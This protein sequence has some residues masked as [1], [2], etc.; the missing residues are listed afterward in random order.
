MG[1]GLGKSSDWGGLS[2]D[3][4]RQ[5]HHWMVVWLGISLVLLGMRAA[6]TTSLR[7][8]PKGLVHDLLDGPRTAAA[9]GAAAKTAVDLSGSARQI[10]GHD[11]ADVVV[12]QDVTGTNNHGWMGKPERDIDPID[13]SAR[14]AMQK[15]NGHF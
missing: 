5:Q 1:E 14:R 9:L 13:I 12:G 3:F 7:A 8:G 15:Q 10:L 11:I 2:G 6:R 4:R